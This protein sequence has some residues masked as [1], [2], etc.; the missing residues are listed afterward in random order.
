M[1]H[2]PELVGES[3]LCFTHKTKMKVRA[4]AADILS[5]WSLDEKN[6]KGK[7]PVLS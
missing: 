1:N 4:A 3:I 6:D 7:K 2:L 5:R